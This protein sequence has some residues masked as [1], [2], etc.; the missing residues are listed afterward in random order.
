[1]DAYLDLDVK[2]TYCASNNVKWTF[3]E[4]STFFVCFVCVSGCDV[5][6]YTGFGDIGGR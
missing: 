3:H 4:S 1:M 2:F 6:Y 5:H